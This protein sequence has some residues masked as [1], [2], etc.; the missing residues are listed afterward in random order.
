MGRVPNYRS[1]S[2]GPDVLGRRC[3]NRW[4]NRGGCP[5]QLV[6]RCRSMAAHQTEA[7]FR[8]N[9]RLF[10]PTMVPPVAAALGSCSVHR[11][12]PINQGL[13]AVGS[14]TRPWFYSA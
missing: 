3:G 5:L 1:C 10:L 9:G 4:D 11:P 13:H 8:T 14:R 12:G 6:T 7:R 2:E